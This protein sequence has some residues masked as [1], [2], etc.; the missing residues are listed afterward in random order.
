M[1][2][3]ELRRNALAA[4]SVFVAFLVTLPVSRLISDATGLTT[5]RS[6]EAVVIA[7]LTAGLGLAATLVGASAGAQTA[8]DGAR[9]AEALLPLSPRRRAALSLAAAALLLLGV[10]AALHL[11]AS[12]CEQLMRRLEPAGVAAW[13]IE[14]VSRLAQTPVMMAAL[15]EILTACWLLAYLL[16]HG[17]GG[18]LLG[19]LL[20]AA[21][22]GGILAGVGLEI[23]HRFYWKLEFTPLV[24][25]LAAFSIAAKL[26]AAG[27]AVPWRERAARWTATRVLAVAL[28]LSAGPAAAWLAALRTYEGL[29]RSAGPLWMLHHHEHIQQAPS[30]AALAAAAASVPLS[31]PR[32]GVVLAGADGI[33]FLVEDARMGPLDLLLRPFD[34]GRVSD[35]AWD[36]KGAFWVERWTR[37]GR[38]FLRR[39]PDGRIESR[40]V[41]NRPYLDL[42]ARDGRVLIRRDEE[43]RRYSYFDAEDFLTRGPKALPLS[44]RELSRGQRPGDATLGCAGRCLERGGRR[45]MLPGTALARGPFP[46]R[47]LGAR[48]GYVAPLRR[49]HESVAV[50]CLDDGSVR[51]GWSLL[52]EKREWEGWPRMRRLPDG[53]LW[54][55]QRESSLVFVE[56]DG[57]ASRLSYARAR[58][59]LGESARFWEPVRRDAETTWFVLPG[60]V[61]RLSNRDGRVRGIASLPRGAQGA[62]ETADGLVLTG[63][64]GLSFMSWDGTIRRLERH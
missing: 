55:G 46:L 38:E 27:L 32:G 50:L 17:V 39:S 54:V 20:A 12:A 10:A 26:G 53:T 15:L 30:P 51:P 34:G 7:W 11:G 29:S 60:R 19:L 43:S 56:A 31:T 18:G 3:V 1:I 48:K 36:E 6:L 28:L 16:G 45:W 47:P 41:P 44:A 13:K 58:K 4:A 63:R 59:E 42:H 8:A 62:H 2:S 37:E 64:D 61:V 24:P 9:D 21:G 57:S 23:V 33:A 14:N 35:A 40:R 22:A 25:W 5:A 52:P 49:G